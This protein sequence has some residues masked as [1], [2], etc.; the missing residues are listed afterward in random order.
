MSRSWRQV[1]W[2]LAVLP[3]LALIGSIVF[4]LN[5]ASFPQN[6]IMLLA[7]EYA[8]FAPI[9]GLLL[10]R[11]RR[12]STELAAPL[13]GLPAGFWFLAYAMAAIPIAWAFGEGIY[14]ADESAYLFQARSL[15]QGS[16]Y[17]TPPAGVDRMDIGFL[18]HIVDDG[19]W[20]GK[21]PFGWPALLAVF[22]FLHAE[23]ILSPLLGGLVLWLTY[24]VARETFSDVDARLAIA[25]MVLSPFFTLN[26]I[27]FMSHPL[28]AALVAAATLFLLRFL[29][30]GNLGWAL[31]MV[32]CI[33]VT[34]VVRPFTAACVGS[35]LALV[36]MWHLRRRPAALAVL[37]G[38]GATLGALAAGSLLLSNRVL[39]GDYFLN[40]YALYD[41]IYAGAD[42]IE[43]LAFS[44]MSLVRSAIATTPERLADTTAT[45][46][47]FLLLLAAYGLWLRRN[48]RSAW[49]L[50]GIFA[51]LL[52]GHFG[53]GFASDS[54]IGERYYFEGMFGVSILAGVAC[55][56]LATDVRLERPTRSSFT[57][58]L[59]VLVLAVWT[60]SLFGFWQRRW[61]GTRLEQA[62]QNPPFSKGIV[63]IA[64]VDVVRQPSNYNLNRPG[65]EVLY[66]P[67]DEPARRSRVLAARPNENWAVL[68][69][70]RL[71]PEARWILAPGGTDR[72]GLEQYWDDGNR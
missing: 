13:G 51:V 49:L 54:P 17:T 4:G 24:V 66:V 46:F 56:R 38:F 34:C 39:T 67:G 1:W 27:G 16:L 33:A 60:V 43:G 8:V 12:P 14:Q 32:S 31:A 23:W 42:E 72:D 5:E 64:D 48:D 41:Q 63:F 65:G 6:K 40:T 53:A 7:S 61:P 30:S 35:L 68:T 69:L 37:C 20:Y 44:P 18:H 70:D 29:K 15:L 58:A 10:W 36:A 25:V 21:Y 28:T 50:A 2:A 9:V 55:R 47:P 26:C 57:A 3:L 45:A 71:G 62:A 19:K 59:G 11:F 22:C 52:V